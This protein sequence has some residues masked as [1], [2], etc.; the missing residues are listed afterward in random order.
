MNSLQV[1]LK[2]VYAEPTWFPYSVLLNQ[3][4]KVIPLAGG[5]CWFQQRQAVARTLSLYQSLFYF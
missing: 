4:V 1:N 2:A 5:H 3:T